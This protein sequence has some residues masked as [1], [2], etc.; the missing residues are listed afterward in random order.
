MIVKLKGNIENIN[1]DS[2][3]IDVNGVVFRVLITSKDINKLKNIGDRLIINIFEIIREDS[4][5]LFGFMDL[6]EKLIFKD[7]IN[8]LKD[9]AS[10]DKLLKSSTLFASK[11]N[12]TLFDDLYSCIVNLGYQSKIAEEVSRQIIIHNKN[13]E[14][15]ELIPLALKTLKIQSK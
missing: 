14:L 4:R 6:N 1:P 10:Y 3:D 9:K 8:E 7:L 13:K 15:E 2:I 5:L 11:K 12:K